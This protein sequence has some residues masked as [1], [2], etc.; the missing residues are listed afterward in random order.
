MK[1]SMVK[2]PMNENR[3][4]AR[5]RNL[6]LLGDP[7]MCSFLHSNIE[8]EDVDGKGSAAD[9]KHD[10]IRCSCAFFAL[11]GATPL[12]NVLPTSVLQDCGR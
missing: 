12:V 6:L 11:C 9:S 1:Q 10:T 8:L 2:K 4:A 3:K 7:P 5:K